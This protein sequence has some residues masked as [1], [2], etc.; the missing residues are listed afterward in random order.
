[1]SEDKN[2]GLF[3][4]TVPV[5]GSFPNVMEA[6]AVKKNGKETG[7]PKFSYNFEFPADHP[8]LKSLKSLALKLAK[9]KWPGR[10]I[11]REAALVDANGNKKLSTFNFPWSLGDSLAE[12]AKK[13]GKDREWSRGRLVL[14][15]RSK[16]EPR[17]SA[18]VNGQLVEF[19][20][21]NQ[22]RALAKKH[23]FTG[24]DVL[25]QVNLQAYEGVGDTGADGVTA[26]LNMVLATGKGKKVGGSA[27]SAADTFKGYI[28]TVSNEDV[29]A[30]LDDDEEVEF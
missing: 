16:Y 17:L 19:D 7:E 20:G 13:N 12:K 22:P 9:A 25:F 24:A 15:A 28:G 3:N 18:I 1:M 2:E 30:G 6:K 21:E 23:F 10:D 11:V 29:A 27:P 5:F 4:S 14:T 8:D 26:Y